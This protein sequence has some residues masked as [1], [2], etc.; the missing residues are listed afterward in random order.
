MSSTAHHDPPAA[1]A[2]NGWILCVDDD[3]RVLEALEL[4]L[5]F[6]HEVRI[7]E[8][9]ERGLALL[10]ANPDCSVIISDM[11]M[12]GMNGAQFLHASTHISPDSTRMLLT[13][14]SE[15][16]DAIAAINE[17]KVYRFLTKPTPPDVMIGAVGDALRQWQLVRSERILLERTLRGAIDTLMEALEIASP[18]AFARARHIGSLAR[19][20]AASLDVQPVW[21]AALA[22]QLFRLG[23]ISVPQGVVDRYLDGI[24]PTE[25]DAAMLEAAYRT[26]ARLVGHIPRLEPVAEIILGAAFRPAAGLTASAIVR[27]A[28]E[29][30][31]LCS[32]GRN[33]SEAAR[34][35][36]ST[37][38]EEIA[39]ALL[40]TPGVGLAPVQREVDVRQVVAGMTVLDD[41]ITTDGNV[42]IRAG[43]ELSATVVERLRNFSRGVGIRQPLRVSS[44]SALVRQ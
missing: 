9:G 1:G 5:G 17:G 4:Q 15:I 33:P 10:R 3:H 24:E 14:Y 30:D 39:K 23:W 21:Q 32:L 25:A 40:S 6:E 36:A 44:P 27:A 28:S 12:P 34:T 41:I 8:G 2:D 11:R 37:F 13:G 7:A 18:V 35:V 20:V 19:H 42:L 43:T 38:G 31:T 22:G 26:S 29:F 16:D